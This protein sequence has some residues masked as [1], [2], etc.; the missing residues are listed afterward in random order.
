MEETKQ[1]QDDDDEREGRGWLWQQKIVKSREAKIQKKS[2]KNDLVN[3][4]REF[5]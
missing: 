3:E 2:G 5:K 1:Q 4:I